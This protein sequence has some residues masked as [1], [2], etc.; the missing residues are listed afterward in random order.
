[1]LDMGL[2][3]FELADLQRGQYHRKALRNI[4]RKGDQITDKIP[5]SSDSCE[6]LT[7]Y[8]ENE[9]GDGHGPIFQSKTAKA[10]AQQDVD[11]LLQAI[12]KQAITRLSGEQQISLSPHVLRHTALRK[13]TEK[14]GVQFARKTAGH[15]SDRNIWRY[16]TP[17]D[18][19]VQQ[20]ADELWD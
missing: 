15:A 19:E 1:M 7:A 10:L 13:W 17:S 14:T 18:D 3:V 12:A 2:R 8:F 4:Q 9:R 5:L 6:A 11:Y 20:A 16:V